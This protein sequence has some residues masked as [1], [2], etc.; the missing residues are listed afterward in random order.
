MTEIRRLVVDDWRVFGFPATYARTD[1]DAIYYLQTEAWDEVWLDFDLGQD[2]HQRIM[3]TVP[4][5]IYLEK[6]YKPSI[7]RIYVHSDNPAGASYL[8]RALERWYDVRRVAT[9]M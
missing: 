6:N 3:T 9:Y 4:V 8:V 1:E 2:G 7:Q 5:A